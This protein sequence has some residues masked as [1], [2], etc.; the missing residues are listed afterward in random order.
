[1]VAGAVDF[2]GHIGREDRVVLA[3]DPPGV[4]RGAGL[5]D[6]VADVVGFIVAGGIGVHHVV[7]PVA[8]EHVGSFH[9]ALQ[10]VIGNAA[11]AGEGLHVVV[12]LHPSRA[13]VVIAGP[14]REVAV[15]R[16]V[17]VLKALEIE[18]DDRRDELVRDEGGLS[19]RFP[20]PDRAVAFRPESHAGEVV[21][22]VVFP[23]LLHAVRR[24]VLVVRVPVHLVVDP[25]DH[26]L[27]DPD[28]RPALARANTVGGGVEGIGVPELLQCRVSEVAGHHGVKIAD[29]VPSGSGL[30]P[31]G[32]GRGGGRRSKAEA[33]RQQQEGD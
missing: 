8:L 29:R 7:L 6:R 16:A 13:G 1:M 5:V 30:A 28:L 32:Q 10:L 9:D 18:R 14:G 27:G 4:D 22:Q 21:E 24:P 2:A 12:E 31:G 11:L 26:V 23:V 19:V 3:V 17:V 15:G 20:R 25:V 33:E